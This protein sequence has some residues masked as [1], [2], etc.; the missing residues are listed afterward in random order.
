VKGLLSVID[1]VANALLDS[2]LGI[3]TNLVTTLG[4]DLGVVGGTTTVPG[5]K[6]R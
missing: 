1:D 2:G 6:L 5:Q 4:N 3:G